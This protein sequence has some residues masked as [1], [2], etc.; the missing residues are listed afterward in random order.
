MKDN[1]EL[2]EGSIL[3]TV[4]LALTLSTLNISTSCFPFYSLSPVHINRS[5][6]ILTYF[7]KFFVQFPAELFHVMYLLFNLHIMLYFL[8]PSE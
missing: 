4:F 6:V 5:Q 7:K 3:R 2:F 8:I 1:G